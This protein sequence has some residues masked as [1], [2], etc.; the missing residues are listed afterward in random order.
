[1]NGRMELEY[2][3]ERGLDDVRMRCMDR[4]KWKLFWLVHP[5]RELKGTGVSVNFTKLE[6]DNQHTYFFFVLSSESS[7]FLLFMRK[8]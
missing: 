8:I 1:M 3:R 7:I 5:L 2:I 4:C 6:Y